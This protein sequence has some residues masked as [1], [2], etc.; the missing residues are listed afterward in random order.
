MIFNQVQFQ[1]NFTLWNARSKAWNSNSKPWNFNFMPWN[2][3]F[4]PW[5][6]HGTCTRHNAKRNEHDFAP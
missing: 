4:M 5:N 6:F 3:N 2:F 1:K